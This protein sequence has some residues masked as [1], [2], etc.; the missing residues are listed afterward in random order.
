MHEEGDLMEHP[1]G[2]DVGDVRLSTR[3]TMI[4]NL[5]SPTPYEVS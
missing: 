1:E 2:E 5:P 3:I 4:V